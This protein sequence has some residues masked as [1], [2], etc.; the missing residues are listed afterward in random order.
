LTAYDGNRNLPSRK[1]NN[2]RKISKITLFLV[3]AVG[4]FGAYRLG[5]AQEISSSKGRPLTPPPTFDVQISPEPNALATN[6]VLMRTYNN[7]G[8]VPTGA[9][10]NT[11]TPI[12]HQL[13]VQCPGTTGSGTCTIQADMWVENGD[14]DSTENANSACLYVD[15]KA[16][17]FCPYSGETPS[18]FSF[19]ASSASQTVSGLVPGNHTVQTYF[20]SNNGTITFTYNNNYRVYKP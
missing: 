18:D 20:Y 9:P 4:F 19:V 2:M 6:H 15:G 10:S 8:G 13:T 12:D 3:L 11:Y 14:S 17:N 5:L 16:T 1:E 7:T